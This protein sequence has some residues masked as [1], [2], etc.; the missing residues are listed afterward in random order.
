MTHQK[1]DKKLDQELSQG[2][3]ISSQQR[4]ETMAYAV[5]NVIY[6]LGANL[7]EPYISFR[8]Q[9]YRSDHLAS[10]P[11]YGNYTQNLVGELSGDIIGASALVAAEA[12]AP[13]QLHTLTRGMRKIIDPFYDRAARRQFANIEGAPDYEQKVEQW[14]LFNER[15]FVR[16][17]LCAATG[18]AGNIAT[19]K[20]ILGNPSPASLIF[21]GKFLST[22]VS[23]AIGLIGRSVFSERTKKMDKWMSGML[24]PLLEEKSMDDGPA[25]SHVDK[26]MQ[27]KGE[28]ELAR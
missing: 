14:K 5:Q 15:N 16:T 11:K 21:A 22:S 8:V 28:P 4:A 1:E 19:Q 12:V 3:T 9:K 7:F 10:H 23:A 2:N 6:N 26:L 20:F 13:V 18:I 17:S 24:Q 27:H 25:P